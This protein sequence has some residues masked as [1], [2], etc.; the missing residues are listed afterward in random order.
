MIIVLK[1]VGLP[2]AV[3]SLRSVALTFLPCGVLS[4]S[5]IEA[6]DTPLDLVPSLVSS[7]RLLVWF[8]VSLSFPCFPFLSSLSVLFVSFSLR[9]FLSFFSC[10]FF[11]FF[12]FSVFGNFPQ[13]T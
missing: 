1:L 3:T 13:L 4:P 2:M 10:V 9:S 12:F 6:L 11:S 7:Q 8:F 5:A